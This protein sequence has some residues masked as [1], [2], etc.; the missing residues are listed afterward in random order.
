MG[1]ARLAM[2][3]ARAV[4]EIAGERR[5]AARLQRT[6]ED[7]FFL[8]KAFTHTS[9][10][11]SEPGL[12]GKRRGAGMQF[13]LLRAVQ[14]TRERKTWQHAGKPPRTRRRPPANSPLHA[15]ARRAA[16]TPLPC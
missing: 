7:V 4:A 6:A 5:E 16:K 14:S 13:A 11:M 2:R 3:R 10:R 8:R 9:A 15:P 1:H 12:H